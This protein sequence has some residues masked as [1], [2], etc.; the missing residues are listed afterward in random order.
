MYIEVI[1]V[2]IVI[3]VIYLCLN[4]KKEKFL[5]E[6]NPWF[7]AKIF[8]SDTGK[9]YDAKTATD[10][11]SKKDNYYTD[12]NMNP[13]AEKENKD[14]GKKKMFYYEKN[15]DDTRYNTENKRKFLYNGFNEKE[16]EIYMKESREAPKISNT[17][18]GS[19][20]FDIKDSK[21]S[22]KIKYNDRYGYLPNESIENYNL[23]QMKKKQDIP[24]SDKPSFS[25]A[26]SNENDI[27]NIYQDLVADG[28]MKQEDIAIDPNYYTNVPEKNDGKN[29]FEIKE[30]VFEMPEN[31]DFDEKY[32]NLNE[33]TLISKGEELKTLKNYDIIAKFS[34]NLNKN[35]FPPENIIDGN[36]NTMGQS[37]ENKNQNL[38][39]DFS[40][41]N[42]SKSFTKHKYDIDK[43]KIYNRED[44]YYSRLFKLKVYIIF[45]NLETNE[46]ITHNVK[47]ENY[48]PENEHDITYKHIIEIQIPPYN[49]I[50]LRKQK[51]NDLFGKLHKIQN[52]TKTF[53]ISRGKPEEEG[54]E[55]GYENGLSVNPFTNKIVKSCPIPAVQTYDFDPSSKG[56]GLGLASSKEEDKRTA[57]YFT[58][59]GGTYYDAESNECRMCSY[60]DGCFSPWAAKEGGD[61]TRVKQYEIQSCRKGKNR[62]CMP[63]SE[64]AVGEERIVSFCGEGG[65][66]V[67]TKCAPCSPCPEGTYKAYG[68]DK[69]DT[70]IDNYCIPMTQC[71]GKPTNQSGYEDPG[72]ENYYYMKKEGTRG[73]NSYDK[74]LGDKNGSYSPHYFKKYGGEVKILDQK[75]RFIKILSDNN[76]IKFKNLNFNLK[77][78]NKVKPKEDPSKNLYGIKLIYDTKYKHDIYKDILNN[79]SLN[80]IPYPNEVLFDLTN[81]KYKDF[82]SSDIVNLVIDN[83]TILESHKSDLY[84]LKIQFITNYGNVFQLDLSDYEKTPPDDKFTISIPEIKKE[85]DNTFYKH[86]ENKEEIIKD[87]VFKVLSE[88]ERK[89]LP[90]YNSKNNIRVITLKKEDEKSKDKPYGVIYRIVDK[91]NNKYKLVVYFNENKNDTKNNNW[92]RVFK[93]TKRQ[94][95]REGKNMPSP[96]YGQDREC[97]KCDVCPEGFERLPGTCTDKNSL[98]NSI[99][100]RKIDVDKFLQKDLSSMCAPNFIYSKQKVK[101]HLDKLNADQ[102]KNDN[103]IRIE[104][105]PLLKD[106]LGE[107]K[108]K[109]FNDLRAGGILKQEDVD[110]L[111]KIDFKDMNNQNNYPWIN[112]LQEELSDEALARVGCVKCSECP[113]GFFEDPLNPGCKNGNDTICREY[114]KCKNDGSERLV[115]KGTKKTDNVCG[116]CKCPPGFIGEN[117]ICDGTDNVQGCRPN[118]ECNV[119]GPSSSGDPEYYYDK[120]GDYGNTTKENECATCDKE[121]PVGTYKIGGCDKYGNGNIICKNHRE[122]DKET[123]LVVEP[124]TST[125]DTVCK[126]IDGFDWPQMFQKDGRS[127]GGK[128]ME[129]NKCVEIQGQCHKNPCHPNANCYDN[130]NN[131]TGAYESTVCRCDLSEGWIETESL[132]FGDNGCKKFPS[133]HFHKVRESEDTWAPGYEELSSNVKNVFKHL[134]EDYHRRQVGKHLHKNYL[135]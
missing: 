69:S 11:I 40:K 16:K 119:A 52:K 23:Y 27:Y 78:K 46:I 60:P 124:G 103:K 81:F 66:K 2:I 115:Q 101:E 77:N 56:L 5:G 70:S 45:K 120:P 126:C 21:P 73:S 48:K 10:I 17:V 58:E 26:K 29:I 96:Y 114:K 54:V 91:G 104:K 82:D 49:N 113:D 30:I 38:I 121:C 72:E 109:N 1:I 63:C 116:P 133:S 51:Y 47:I 35:G 75:I 8:N 94:K 90:N 110:R 131:D 25:S 37:I 24:N 18:R 64:C 100:Q 89:K 106:Y 22:K 127:F 102:E 36:L 3:V 108:T 118:K 95:N 20:Y 50:K 125:K 7:N 134:G 83:N 135:P 107:N 132:G 71:K 68:C 87:A 15:S 31:L 76:N 55:I 9:L 105:Y 13:S 79:N 43:I 85:A 57:K 93:T 65:G 117:P 97:S 67:D 33:I 88:E 34:Q 130:F 80:N 44:Q 42:K 28:T 74:N 41:A 61:P 123:M 111:S 32:I 84:K 129:A 99:C 62:E 39:I 12:S 92:V 98:V 112:N 4:K 6:N 122:C 53:V 128:N 86:L 19:L 59:K 14:L